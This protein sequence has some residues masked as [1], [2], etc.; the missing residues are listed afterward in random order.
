MKK[1]YFGVS[2]IIF[3]F[4]LVG[5]AQNT[6]T[7]NGNFSNGTTLYSDLV[8]ISDLIKENLKINALKGGIK[9]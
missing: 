9:K 3:L 7:F 4:A 8:N 6:V 1:V 5:A 2:M